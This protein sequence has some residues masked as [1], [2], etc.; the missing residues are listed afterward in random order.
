M[1]TFVKS[2]RLLRNTTKSLTS[3]QNRAM[4]YSEYKKV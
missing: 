4:S 2:L 1:S 3:E